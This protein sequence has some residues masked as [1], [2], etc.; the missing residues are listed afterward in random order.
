LTN[1]APVDGGQLGITAT[2]PLAE[3]ERRLI[4]AALEHF[5]GDRRKVA[6]ALG[7]SLRTLYNRLRQYG[8]A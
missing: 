2:T 3:A 8:S 1:A 5:G 4:L 6:A 7:V